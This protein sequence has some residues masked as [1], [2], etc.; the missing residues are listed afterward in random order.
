[1]FPPFESI[2]TAPVESVTAPVKVIPSKLDQL[3]PSRVVVPVNVDPVSPFVRVTS[4]SKRV[5]PD[6][7]VELMPDAAPTVLMNR[8]RPFDARVRAAPT[9]SP[10]PET[11]P[12]KVVVPA[13]VPAAI[14]MS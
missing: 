7:L 4:P 8:T 9:P 3:R 12:V 2:E 14:V 1:M 5:D 13:A 11:A 6:A 10:R